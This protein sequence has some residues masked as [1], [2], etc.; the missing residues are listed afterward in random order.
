[1]QRFHLLAVSFCA[2]SDERQAVQR[3]FQNP[4]VIAIGWSGRVGLMKI[5]FNHGVLG[6]CPSR[7][8]NPKD[9]D[10]GRPAQRAAQPQIPP[11]RHRGTEK[12][13]P[14]RAGGR[15]ARLGLRPAMSIHRRI[16][17]SAAIVQAAP[18]STRSRAASVDQTP[19]S[20]QLKVRRSGRPPVRG[21]MRVRCIDRPQ[22]GHGGRTMGWSPTGRFTSCN[23]NMVSRRGAFQTNE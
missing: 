19:H 11:Q 9:Q 8:T 22:F 10:R 15:N 4:S 20:P 21:V 16:Q 7:L 17:Y 1:M 6:S 13:N 23:A 5:T 12:R 14:K 3:P 2:P 18:R